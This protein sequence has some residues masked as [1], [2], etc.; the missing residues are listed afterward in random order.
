MGKF[1]QWSFVEQLIMK[2]RKSVKLEES[3]ERANNK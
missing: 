2:E 1:L 3:A